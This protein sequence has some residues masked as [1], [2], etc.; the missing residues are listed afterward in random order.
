MNKKV[1]S[2]FDRFMKNSKQ[3]KLYNEEYKELLLSE[4]FLALMEGDDFSVR[5]LAKVAGISPTVI[6]EVKSGKKKNI[7]LETFLKI[8]AACGW[9]V[10]VENPRKRG[11][12]K[13]VL[14]ID[15]ALA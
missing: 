12:M 7:T 1:L 5:K 10:V 6:Q 8:V 4:L 3:K 11:E 13:F 2:T 15:T 9:T 14:N